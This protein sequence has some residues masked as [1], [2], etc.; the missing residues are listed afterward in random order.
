[1]NEGGGGGGEGEGEE[2]T[3]NEK[4][5]EGNPF[6]HLASWSLPHHWQRVRWGGPDGGAAVSILSSYLHHYLLHAVPGNHL[7]TSS[8]PHIHLAAATAIIIIIA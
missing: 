2:K 6:C 4:K 7:H 5:I 3:K 8:A 1:M